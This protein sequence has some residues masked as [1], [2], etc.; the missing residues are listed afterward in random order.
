MAK[1]DKSNEAQAILESFMANKTI[2]TPKQAPI[3]PVF[4]KETKKEKEET[5]RFTVEIEAQLMNDIKLYGVHNKLKIRQIFEKALR[6]FL[7]KA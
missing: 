7:N 2:D 6:E 1:K 3:A 4:T 5:T